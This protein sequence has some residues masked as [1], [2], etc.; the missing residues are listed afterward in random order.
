MGYGDAGY[1]DI[2]KRLEIAGT[3]AEFQVAM[4]RVER[5]RGPHTPE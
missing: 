3:A 5:R 4:R 1:Q 2:A